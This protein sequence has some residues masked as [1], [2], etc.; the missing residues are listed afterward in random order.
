MSMLSRRE[1]LRT[2]GLG[3]GAGVALPGLLP[4]SQMA[5]AM[6]GGVSYADMLRQME[7]DVT[8]ARAAAGPIR[9]MYN[10]NPFGMSPK[11]KDALMGHWA[12]HTWYVPPIRQE[13][14]ATFAKHVGVPVENVLVTQGSSEVLSILA[15]AYNMDGGEIVA[16]WPTFEDLPRWGDTLKMR[17][18]RVPLDHNLDHDL[19]QMDAKIGGA[20]KLVFVCNPNNPTSNLN[21]DKALRDFVGTASKRALVVVDEAYIDFVDTPGHKSMVDLVLKGE[22]VVVSRTASKLHGLAGLR[23]GFAIARADIVRKL[24]QYV[25]GDPNVFGLHAANASLQDTEYQ[26][27]AKAKNREGRTLLLD[28]LAKL[29]KKAAPSQTNFVFFQAGKPVEAMQGY[30]RSKGYLIGRAFPPY[31]DWCRVSVGTPEEM[32]GF[33]EVLPGAWG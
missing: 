27:F 21:D 18:H 24:Q 15:L 2:T 20:T 26:T 4:A 30:F 8:T 9:L 22:N 23:V 17:V 28:T 19:Y 11:A 32:K 13:V 29:G 7:R 6:G 33:C 25:T 12:E 31:T 3:V 14:A 16:P 1:W 5:H 10:E